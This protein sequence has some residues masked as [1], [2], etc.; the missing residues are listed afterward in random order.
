MSANF[1]KIGVYRYKSLFVHFFRGLCICVLFPGLVWAGPATYRYDDMDRLTQS[2]SAGGALT[3]YQYDSEGNRT[4]L[5]ITAGTLSVPQA[6]FSADITEGTA[7]LTVHFTDQSAGIVES[8]SWDF[9]D[10]ETGSEQ[11]PVHKYTSPGTYTVS[12]TASNR[13][14][15][16]TATLTDYITVVSPQG[17]MPGISISHGFPPGG[18]GVIDYSQ[19][20]EVNYRITLT[21]TGEVSATV[22]V[23]VDLA[24]A[25]FVM[26]TPPDNCIYD[27]DQQ[28]FESIAV[29]PGTPVN[30]DYTARYDGGKTADGDTIETIAVITRIRDWY[31]A[32][33]GMDRGGHGDLSAAATATVAA[34]SMI[35]GTVRDMSSERAVY[36][37]L[38]SATGGKNTA[39]DTKGNYRLSLN[40][41]VYTVTVSKSGYQTATLSTIIVYSEKAT[42]L[43]VYMTT[44]G[45]LNIIT[46]HIN[47]GL[48]GR[49][50]NPKIRVSGGVYPYTYSMVSGALP[51]GI[52]LDTA[53]GNL[54]GT[55]A[56]AGQYTF[57]IGVRDK[58]NA[59]AERQFTQVIGEPLHFV[60]PYD[61]PRA[62]TEAAYSVRLS[63]DGGTAPYMF[64][65]VGNTLPDGFRLDQDGLISGLPSGSGQH[66]FSVRVDDAAGGT[67][68]R[69]FTLGIDAPLVIGTVRLFSGITGRAFN[70]A[71]EVSGGYGPYS[72]SVVSGGLPGGILLSDGRLTG[73]P[74]A[75][76]KGNVTLSVADGAGRSAAKAF[77][78]EVG[79]PLHLASLT[80]PSAMKDHQYSAPVITDGGVGDLHY[81]CLSPLPPG[82]SISPGTGEITG[83]ASIVGLSNVI[84][85]VEDQAVPEP[86]ADERTLTLRVVEPLEIVTD[87]FPEAIQG[88]EYTAQ[89]SG[90]GGA[91]PYEW[92]V[93]FGHMPQGTDLDPVTGRIDGIPVE[94][95]LFDFTIRLSDASDPA[96]SVDR[97][98][99]LKVKCLGDIN[100]DGKLDLNDAVLGMA[101]MTGMSSGADYLH[102]D[103]NGDG[104]IGLEEEIYILEVIAGLR[105]PVQK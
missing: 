15:S 33:S 62:A 1:L 81:T 28:A 18:D 49:A 11:N 44:P 101:V 94:C 95:G 46:D 39:T 40:P 66:Y 85:R 36:N 103:V 90:H 70:Q 98:Y 21:N 50:Q 5:S 2:V 91:E 89:L 84:V 100:E 8:W 20:R 41:G 7:P 42:V 56:A 23:M 26:I 93:A 71:L 22:D 77:S 32:A 25:G 13:D 3:T 67:A 61:L 64:A 52:H 14:A 34:R 19:D 31:D 12:L 53:N 17:P 72:W 88:S 43:N 27:A 65:L 10:G 29:E 47:D 60:T 48:V 83:T 30:L 37:A 74:A 102:A 104:R 63:A 68:T 97:A 54:A 78:W 92:S 59:Y 51:P 55:P 57:T 99:E 6:L 9:G 105:Q 24:S 75:A 79:N 69:D 86:Q 4:H 76:G 73:T 82:L 16:D 35:L 87:K 80:L 58:N 45:A 38:I 96:I